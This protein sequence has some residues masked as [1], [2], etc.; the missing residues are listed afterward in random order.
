LIQF[1]D[2]EGSNKTKTITLTPIVY[3]ITIL[4]D[5]AE[6]DLAIEFMELLLSN[7][8]NT[9]SQDNFIDPLVPAVPTTDSAGIPN[10]LNQYIT[11]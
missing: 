10:Q 8:G 4:T 5:A 11:S 3:G 1:S 6:N 7:E 2:L 9:I